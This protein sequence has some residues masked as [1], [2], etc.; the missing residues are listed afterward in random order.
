M[1]YA[2]VYKFGKNKV[3]NKLNHK[4]KF[5]CNKNNPSTNN[6]HNP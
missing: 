4:L 1:E 3:L 5:P 6:I 2:W